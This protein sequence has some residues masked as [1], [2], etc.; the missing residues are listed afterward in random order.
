M[1]LFITNYLKEDNKIKIT[2]E[3]VV[4]QLNKVLRAHIG[5]VFCVQ[6]LEWKER[7]KL[8]IIQINKKE[9]FCKKIEEL[10]KETILNQKAWMII[11]ILNKLS[12]MELIVQK[13]S[14]IW[15]SEIIF[16]P[17][18]RSQIKEIS[19]KKLE[20]LNKI[21]L[22]ATEQSW[23]WNL[24]KIILE[25]S[26]IES[27][28]DK[29]VVLFHQ[30]GQKIIEKNDELYWIIWPEWWFTEKELD[31][32]IDKQKV[33]LWNTILRAETAAIIG[34]WKIKN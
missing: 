3:R 5:Y 27:I 4:Q 9:I 29:N 24:P 25:K 2:E 8:E 21:I 28:K 12:K 19:A 7:L 26:L 31:L 23:G 17:F 30:D 34:W 6:N 14:E 13:L 15:I 22:E 33:F 10:T 32:F 11:A 20:R 18:E 16:S 1:Q